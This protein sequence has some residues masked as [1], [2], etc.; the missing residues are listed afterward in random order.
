[1]LKTAGISASEVRVLFFC[2]A[3]EGLIDPAKYYEGDRRHEA[4][5]DCILATAVS[6]K[7]L[8]VSCK[9]VTAQLHWHS[10]LPRD[11]YLQ[12]VLH[13]AGLDG[14]GCA[15]PGK[16]KG[17]LHEADA[18]FPLLACACL[19]KPQLGVLVRRQKALLTDHACS[20]AHRPKHHS[21][22]D[23]VALMHKEKE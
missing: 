4:L 21:L 7:G 13:K 20:N 3:F 2:N 10:A 19:N 9:I 16:V 6:I 14:Q 23:F 18:S 12:M 17:L 11:A 5:A 1:M 15:S 22:Q 8:M